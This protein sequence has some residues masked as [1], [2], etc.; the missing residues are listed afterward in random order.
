MSRFGTTLSHWLRLLLVGCLCVGVC[1]QFSPAA[2]SITL[3]NGMQLEGEIGTV[4]RIGEDPLSVVKGDGE[5]DIKNVVVVDDQLA[6]IFVSTINVATPPAPSATISMERLRITQRV[7]SSGMRVA[8]LGPVIRITPWSEFGRRI[9]S[10][11]TLSGPVDVVQGITEVTPLYCKVEA[12]VGKKMFIW[13]MRIATSS[14]P[15]ET[16][17]RILLNQIDKES[18]DDRLKIVRLYIQ[19]ERYEDAG[20]EL[21]Q[22]IED[23]PELGELKVQIETLR[24]FASRRLLREAE[25]RRDAGQYRLAFNMLAKFPDEGVAGA[26]LLRVREMLG[27]YDK[28]QKQGESVLKLMEEHAAAIDNEKL[29]ERILPIQKEISGELNVNTLDR[30]ADYLRLS[31][32]DKLKADQKLALAIS[33]WL[34]G[35]GAGT[36]NLAVALS[37]VEVRDAVRRYLR[38]DRH[39][40]RVE[41]LEKLQ[42]QEG[43]TPEY[44]AKIL[45][46]MKPPM[47]TQ[48]TDAGVPGMYELK[49]QGLTGE[50]DITFF[51]QLPRDYDASRRYP[52]VVTMHG[53]GRTPEQQIQWWAGEYDQERGMRLGQATRRGYIVVAPAWTKEHQAKYGYTA[54]EHAAVLLSLKN[55]CRRFSIDTDRV[56]LSG[57]SIGGDAAWD[58]GL[59][60]PD[61]W[62]GVIPIVAKADKYVTRYHENARH[63]LPMYFVAGQ[64][65]GTRMAENADELNRYLRYPGFDA[66][67]VEYRG[68]GHEHF[69][70]EIQR[71][72]DWMQLPSHRR[73]FFPRDF[74]CVSMR[75]WDNF[76]WWVELEDFAPNTVVSPLEWPDNGRVSARPATT[77]ARVLETNGVFV[78]PG[79]RKAT[80]WLS[81]QI[82]DFG[83]RMSINGRIREVQPSIEVM[84]ED[85]RTRGDRLHPFWAKVEAK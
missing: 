29:R 8:G 3:K 42:G 75:K 49:V 52:C 72:F 34:L 51:V 60:H 30:M 6:R 25:L 61:L 73:N 44:V 45:A 23:F 50:P 32:D 1:P 38:S 53:A 5:V 24:Q 69:H 14:V 55:A 39:H 80:V 9:Y 78:N 36:E 82:V 76:F 15:R 35:S 27:E 26:T 54:Q 37:L 74:K 19:A 85:V 81:P 20:E 16:L 56:F 48:E 22:V 28:I 77:D 47:D 11:N 33:G 12:L 40:E 79:S 57:H 18:A 71:I 7:A 64:L 59:A 17:S 4:A 84:L 2:D 66:T 21:K 41:I 67:V 62:A 43:A 68:R 70:D 65:D 63:A 46:H 31:D 58:I 83:E 10:M 13:D